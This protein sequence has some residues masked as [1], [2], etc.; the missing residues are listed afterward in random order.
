MC[1]AMRRTHPIIGY[2]TYCA[3]L[4]VCS[5]EANPS[6]YRLSNILCC[7]YVCSYEANPSYYRLSNILCCT[8]V[9]SYEV[10][11]SYYRLSNILCCTY[12]CSYEANPSYGDSATVENQLLEL[13]MNMKQTKLDLDTLRGKVRMSEG[14]W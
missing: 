10:N 5:Y 11:P 12:V 9:C 13:Q 8:Y 4:Y 3:V 14:E 1:V 2:P 6:Y 7:T